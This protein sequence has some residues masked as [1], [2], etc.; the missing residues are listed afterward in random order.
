[1]CRKYENINYMIVTQDPVNNSILVLHLGRGMVSCQ[2]G[3]FV[4]NGTFGQNGKLGHSC[5][6]VTKGKLYGSRDSDHAIVN[7]GLDVSSS[8]HNCGCVIDGGNVMAAI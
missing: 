1:M 3:R 7:L 6:N 4:Q 5:T 8:A 2:N